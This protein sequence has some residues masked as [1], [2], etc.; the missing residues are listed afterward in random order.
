MTWN[1]DKCGVMDNSRHH[2]APKNLTLSMGAAAL[3]EVD[4][5]KYLGLP[6]GRKGISWT[7]YCAQLVAKHD[8]ILKATIVRRKA[9]SMQTRLTIYKVFIR[10]TLEYCLA[11]LWAWLSKQN[12]ALSHESKKALLSCHDNALEWIFDTA[13]PRRILE[14][15]SGLGDFES[16]VEMLHGSMAL[17]LRHLDP[18]NPLSMHISSHPISASQHFIL[19]LCKTS[20]LLD[21][22]QAQSKDPTVWVGWQTWCR[23][24]W[25]KKKTLIQ[26]TCSLDTSL[27]ALALIA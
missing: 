10:S 6:H 26:A 21:S 19:Q 9:W 3:P 4:S 12:N 17:H 25:M 13:Q 20:P 2:E 8:K 23:R 1:I 27:C 24:S 14:N 16:R 22:W 7:L 18:S 5:Y 11:P 15:V